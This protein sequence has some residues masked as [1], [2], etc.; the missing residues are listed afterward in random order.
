MKRD[1]QKRGWLCLH[2]PRLL[3]LIPF[4]AMMWVPSYNRAEPAVRVRRTA[5]CQ[6]RYFSSRCGAA[7]AGMKRRSRCHVAAMVSRSPAVRAPSWSL[8]PARF[9]H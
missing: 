1:G 3:F 7:I 2:W 4:F 5:S 8:L 6:P 9:A